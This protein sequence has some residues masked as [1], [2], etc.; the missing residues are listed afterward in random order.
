MI[1]GKEKKNVC[2]HF[3]HFT[4][5]ATLVPKRKKERIDRSASNVPVFLRIK[6]ET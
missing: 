3:L 2:S 4:D 1:I 5:F 6:G